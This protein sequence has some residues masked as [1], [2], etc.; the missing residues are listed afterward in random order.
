MV[1]SKD[2]EYWQRIVDRFEVIELLDYMD[3][4]VEELLDAF[5]DKWIDNVE[6]QEA[7]GIYLG[8]DE[9]ISETWD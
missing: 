6:L 1:R 3:V 2:K 4:T 7:V 8:T 5:E 9:E